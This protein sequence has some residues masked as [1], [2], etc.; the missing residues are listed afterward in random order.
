MEKLGREVTHLRSRGIIFQ[1]LL[2]TVG[3]CQA[4]A[5]DGEVAMAMVD[6]KWGGFAGDCQCRCPQTD[7][8]A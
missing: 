4:T 5:L 8:L 3:C 2:C 6:K 1:G 7:R